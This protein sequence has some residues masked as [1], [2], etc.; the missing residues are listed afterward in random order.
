[1]ELRF[2]PDEV[3]RAPQDAMTEMSY[4]AGLRVSNAT[5]FRAD[6]LSMPLWAQSPL[7]RFAFQFKSF[8]INQTRFIINEVFG[9]HGDTARRLRAIAVLT[10]AYPAIGIGLTKARAGLMGETI[11]S[12]FVDEAL[13]RDDVQGWLM[14][15]AA[16]F[17][18]AGALGIVADMIATTALGNKFAASSFFIPPAASTA[19]NA[20]DIGASV[21]RGLATGDTEQYE[22]AARTLSRELGGL[23]AA[24]VEQTL[25][26]PTRGGGGVAFGGAGFGSGSAGFGRGF[27][28]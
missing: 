28:R 15:G 12:E 2:K 1:V 5:Q 22:R 23:G 19:L 26:E 17:A 24:V 18:T 20:L 10:T 8:A 13:A 14:A 27:G 7:G 25:G 9:R 3:L 4:L 11:T 16:G 6:V 21:V